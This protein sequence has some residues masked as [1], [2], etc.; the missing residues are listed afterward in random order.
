MWIAQVFYQI[1][2]NYYLDQGYCFWEIT[3]NITH[4]WY[5]VL[6]TDWTNQLILGHIQDCVVISPRWTSNSRKS[7]SSK[8]QQGFSLVRGTFGIKTS[9]RSMRKQ[10]W[11]PVSDNTET[12]KQ[13]FLSYP[14]GTQI[15][16][17]TSLDPEANPPSGLRA[18]A[19]D[20]TSF[21][22]PMTVHLS[23]K[24]PIFVFLQQS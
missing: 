18:V 8:C 9:S 21:S 12:I 7:E 22:C 2:W 15:L 14:V 16:A 1:N 19:N 17:V 3:N 5:G 11:M 13:T 24:S 10:N 20:L 4:T 23:L 6:S